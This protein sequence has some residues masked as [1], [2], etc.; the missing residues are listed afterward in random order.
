MST[1]S[2]TTLPIGNCQLHILTVGPLSKLAAFTDYE[3][4][5]LLESIYLGV[6]FLVASN[7]VNVSSDGRF[8]V[9]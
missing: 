3:N 9:Q 5:Y 7:E 6:E 2:F 8:E 1:E 4:W